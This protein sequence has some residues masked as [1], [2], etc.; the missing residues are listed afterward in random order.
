MNDSGE[1]APG[2]ER[3]GEAGRLPCQM[4]NIDSGTPNG[5]YRIQLQS[6]VD[7]FALECKDAEDTLVNAA[8]RLTA[9]EPFR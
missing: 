3:F 7:R 4:A 2:A 5:A 1:D 8:Q 9:D 6:R